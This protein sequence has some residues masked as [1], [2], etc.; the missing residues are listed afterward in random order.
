M[1]YYVPRY[2]VGE[3][4]TT[5]RVIYQAFSPPEFCLG[6]SARLTQKMSNL[7]DILVIGGTGAQ[8]IPVVHGE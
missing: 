4:L 2:Q 5:G 7:K 1:R 8:G 3:T 6:S